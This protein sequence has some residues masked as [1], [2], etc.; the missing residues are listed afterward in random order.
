M[1]KCFQVQ[2]GALPAACCPC[3]EIRL[4]RQQGDDSQNQTGPWRR[5]CDPGLMPCM[6]LQ[7]RM[8][9][10]LVVLVTAHRNADK[11]GGHRLQ[12]PQS[13]HHG[14]SE[15]GARALSAINKTI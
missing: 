9:S 10:H 11:E 7:Q 13:A 4:V 12:D 14:I 8:G 6:E 15:V 1:F 3:H 2:L 5:L